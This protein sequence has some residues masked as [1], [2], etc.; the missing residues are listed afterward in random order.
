MA[1]STDPF[2][3]F[4]L[5]GGE[6]SKRGYVNSFDYEN[7]RLVATFT[8]PD[9]KIWKTFASRL[10]Y[11]F[12][13]DEWHDF[14]DNKAKSYA[15]AEAAGVPIP[16]TLTI[17]TDENLDDAKLAALVNINTPLIV[18]PND[19]LS[20][21]GLTLNI[22]DAQALRAA[23]DNARAVNGASVLV[24]QQVS[25]DEVRFVISKGKV[26]AALLR[27]TPR[28]I[29]DG[30]KSI[31][32]LIAAENEVRKTL[33][34]EYITYPLLTEAIIDAS[35]LHSSRIPANGEIVELSKATMIKK[36]ASVYEIFN[37]MHPSYIQEIQELAA[38]ADAPFF[39]ADF[40]IKDY[41]QPC[42]NDNYWFLEFNVTP[43]LRLCYGCRDGDMFDVLPLAA[44]LIDETLH[45]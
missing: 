27:Q 34:F 31:R 44:D 15:Y 10:R 35:F 38:K 5:I 32:E 12:I 14:S 41:T 8:S 26:V 21:K 33:I 39:V 36:G 23:I 13:S 9:G 37:K 40:I 25:G 2:S 20:S 43:S 7:N 16:F 6:L 29:G 22:T 19:S 4:R 30:V 1:L 42:T 17:N 28:V 45:T 18:K 24:Q 11:P 3:A